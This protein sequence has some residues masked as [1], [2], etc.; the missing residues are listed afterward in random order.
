MSTAIILLV[1]FFAWALFVVLILLFLKGATMGD[2]EDDSHPFPL[3]E[4]I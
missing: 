1:S 4:R 3:D 2:D